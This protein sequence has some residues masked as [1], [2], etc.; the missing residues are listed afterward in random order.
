MSFFILAVKGSP[1][2]GSVL[3]PSPPE[4]LAPPVAGGPSESAAPLGVG[5]GVE[6][7]GGK[8]GEVDD[9]GCFTCHD[10]NNGM[11]VGATSCTATCRL[12]TFEAGFCGK[13]AKVDV[14]EFWSNC[15]A[16]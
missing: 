7:G 15:P 2:Q 1:L 11:P 8:G 16:F 10:V 6:D 5:V 14:V 13:V 3:V 12:L 4:A 9:E